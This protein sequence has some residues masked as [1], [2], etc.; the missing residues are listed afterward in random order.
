MATLVFLTDAEDLTAVQV[1]Q[2]LFRSVLMS[3]GFLA[4][5]SA[6]G[7]Y[8]RGSV[9]NNT[10]LRARVLVSAAAETSLE[11][12]VSAPRAGQASATLVLR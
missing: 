10:Q 5:N 12:V 8:D 9:F 7:L 4:V 2:G 1:G 3:M 11:L 6:L